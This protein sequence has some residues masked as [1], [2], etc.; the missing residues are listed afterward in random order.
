MPK[1][2]TK[3]PRKVATKTSV[4][5]TSNKTTSQKASVPKKTTRRTKKVTVSE[6]V[7]TQVVETPVTDTPSP[8]DSKKPRQTPSRDTVLTAFDELI[9]MVDDEIQRLR[10]G[11]IKTKGIKFLRSLNKRVKTLRNQTARVTKQKTKTPRKGNNNSGF[12]KPVKISKELAKFAGWSEDELRSRVEVTK[13]I[14]DY[15]SEHNLQNP[16]DRRQIKPDTKLQ[17][18]LGYNPKTAEQPLRYYSIQTQLKKQNHFPK[19]E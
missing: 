13:Y 15:I 16:D 5:K 7:E 12:Q 1:A 10:D 6:N 11:P 3:R 18:L 17:K 2:L 4:T 19:N 14:C 9:E 8:S